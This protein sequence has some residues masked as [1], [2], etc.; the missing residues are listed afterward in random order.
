MAQGTITLTRLMIGMYAIGKIEARCLPLTSLDVIQVS[1]GG[2]TI[3]DVQHAVRAVVDVA[4]VLS[5][6]SE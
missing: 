3:R 1:D 6:V 2:R 5:Q 4:T